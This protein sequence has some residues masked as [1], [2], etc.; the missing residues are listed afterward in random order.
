MR[1]LPLK[2]FLS[3]SLDWPC[4][5]KKKLKLSK[6]STP[7]RHWYKADT[8]KFGHSEMCCLLDSITVKVMVTKSAARWVTVL[9]PL[10]HLG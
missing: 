2:V 4:S 10:Q 3:H 5:D 9:E 6:R 8:R 1:R 7:T